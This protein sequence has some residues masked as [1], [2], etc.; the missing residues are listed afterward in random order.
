MKT[1]FCQKLKQSLPA[2]ERAPYPGALGQK[3]LEQISQQA[4]KEW[5]GQQTIL[6][7]ENRLNVLDPSSKTFLEHEM[8]QFLF[9]SDSEKSGTFIVTDE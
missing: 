6:I 1:I 8:H 9:D 4:W 3:I 2:L 7:N 5:L